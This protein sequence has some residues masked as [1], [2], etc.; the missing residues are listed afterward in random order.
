[1]FNKSYIIWVLLLLL[2]QEIQAQSKIES[3]T[4]VHGIVKNANGALVSSCSISVVDS[5]GNILHSTISDENGRFKINIPQNESFLK[6]IARHMS[7]GFYENVINSHSETI[8]IKMPDKLFEM[9]E[10]LVQQAKLSQKGDTLTY[11]LESFS[12]QHDRTL[13][14]VLS[15]I[16]GIEVSQNGQIKL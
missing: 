14:D 16:P 8:E 1:M 10:V 5:S 15:K 3:I 9:E 6:V 13:A 4:I 12:N 7:Y 2:F 11:L